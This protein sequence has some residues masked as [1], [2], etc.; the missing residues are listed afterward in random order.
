MESQSTFYRALA[1]L[2]RAALLVALA[3]SGWIVYQRLPGSGAPGEASGAGETTVQIV[4]RRS[5]EIQATALDIPIE[6]SPIDLV[7]ATHEYKVEPRPGHPLSEFLRERMNGRT[8]VK[9]RLDSQGR[10]SVL[11]PPGEW[12][13]H[14][15]LPGEEDL[16]WRLH[17]TVSGDKQTIELTLQ[18]TFT[19]YKSF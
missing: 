4:L 13:L 10:A 3:G 11:L 9:S 8:E 19:R 16:E 14:A 2:A 15:V 7:A 17:L 1:L 12:W 5:S 6:L 18:N